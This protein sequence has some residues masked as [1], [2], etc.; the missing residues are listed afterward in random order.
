MQKQRDGEMS[1]EA[2]RAELGEGGR[3]K[4]RYFKKRV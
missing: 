2:G 3:V 1:E 4:R